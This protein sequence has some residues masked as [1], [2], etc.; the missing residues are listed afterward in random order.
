MPLRGEV[1]LVDLGMAQKVRPALI[2]SVPYQDTDRA[3]IA[4]VSHTTALRGSQ[5]EVS[6]TVPFLKPGAFAVQSL[7]A[8][9]SKFA[10]RKLGSLTSEQIAAVEQSVRS[11]LGL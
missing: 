11:W 8:I 9:P 7:A 6:I 10:I 1:W 5:F 4:I 2:L 3:L